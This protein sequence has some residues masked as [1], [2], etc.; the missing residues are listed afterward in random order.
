MDKVYLEYLRNNP[1]GY[2]FKRK[3]YGWGWVPVKWQG[4]L[5]IAA[6]IGF[7]LWNGFSLGPAEPTAA[8]IKSFLLRVFAAVALMLL[9]C[10]KTGEKPRWQWGLSEEEKK[11]GI[12]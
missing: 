11:N 4:W 2:W 5:V 1:K 7:L 10:Y 12:K 6:F 8:E 3:L 9:I